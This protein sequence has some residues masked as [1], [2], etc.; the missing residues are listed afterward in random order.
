MVDQQA[1]TV[2][3]QT[4]KTVVKEERVKVPLYHSQS[5]RDSWKQAMKVAGFHVLNT[6]LVSC[7]DRECKRILKT[8]ERNRSRRERIRIVKIFIQSDK[9]Q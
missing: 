7:I 1:G 2:E 8:D 9:A 4:G 6:F 5:Q 3:P